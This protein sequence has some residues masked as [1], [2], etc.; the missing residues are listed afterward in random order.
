[1][2]NSRLKNILRELMAVD[3]PLSSTYLANVNHVTPRTTREDIKA[4]NSWLQ[5]NGADIHTRMGKGFQLEIHD[6]ARFREFLK[7]LDDPGEAV[8]NHLPESPE[9]RA[10]YLLKELLLSEGYVKLDDLAEEMF[11]SKSTIQNDLKEVKKLLLNYDLSLESRP[12]YGLK[13]RGEEMKVR[14]CLSEYLFNQ[15]RI[16]ISN[17]LD[18]FSKE[19]KETVFAILIRKINE[20]NI[21]LSDIAVN[22]LL[23]HILIAYKRVQSGNHVEIYQDDVMEIEK[24]EQYQVAA[25]ILTE[26][27]HALHVEFPN[28]EIAYIGLHLLGTKLLTT[29]NEVVEQVMDQ[30]VVDLVK[31]IL[32]KIEEEFNLGIRGDQELIVALRLHLKPAINR[33]KYGMNIRNPML[34]DIKKNYPLA[35]ETGVTAGVVIEEHTGISI[36]ENEVGYLALHF[37]AAI[38]RRKLETGPKKCL[39]VCASGMGTAKLIYYKLKSYFGQQLDIT[40]TTEYY[41]LN[42]YDLAEIDFVVSSIPI[43]RLDIPVIEV[44]T[45]VS[46]SDLLR[47][48]ETVVAGKKAFV[49]Y[50]R[51]DLIY[52]QKECQSKQEILEFMSGELMKKALVD[53]T[54][55]K[56]VHDREAVAPTSFGN[57]VAIPHP[58]APQSSETF[59]S[60][61]TLKNPV[62]WEEKP[63]QLICFLCVK[64]DSQEDLQVLYEKL[65]QIIDHPSTVQKFIKAES[66]REFVH[67]YKTM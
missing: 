11:I 8:V 36:D 56:A 17:T 15:Q 22:N 4:V 49:D 46:E 54:F 52:L 28:I 6:A 32:G 16:R 38:E 60:F 59:L 57:L 3:Y 27:E 5:K 25:E 66:F 67:A 44:N 64:K 61:C 10:A 65:G 42:E 50:I 62:L 30:D 34:E 14:F 7:S 40:G 26:V 2:L 48:E 24:Q 20:H 23:I 19:E 39:I 9:G 51:Q 45:I 53:N 31:A 33:F 12:N 35:F 58:I 63:V 29:T 37:G 55:L 18:S 47:I 41:K 21:T 13:I 1:M 43:Q